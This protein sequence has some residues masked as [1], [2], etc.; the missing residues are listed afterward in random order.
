M[1]SALQSIVEWAEN[2]LAAWQS[3]GVRR[4]LTQDE[5]DESDKKDVLA[6]LKDRHDLADPQNQPPKPQPIRKGHISGVP[7]TTSKITIKV[8]DR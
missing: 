4:M 8:G 5:L 3:D 2:E 7:Q 1:S 6:M